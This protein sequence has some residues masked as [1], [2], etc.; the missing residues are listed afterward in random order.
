V[1]KGGCESEREGRKK[2]DRDEGK[3]D[4]ERWKKERRDELQTDGRRGSLNQ[5]AAL[6]GQLRVRVRVRSHLF[7]Q[8]TDLG[9]RERGQMCASRSAEGAREAV[10]RGGK[11]KTKRRSA[12][13]QPAL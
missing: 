8:K 6:R 11:R 2:G 10:M 1:P 4:V 3:V 12:R 7:A 5:R 9:T 13:G